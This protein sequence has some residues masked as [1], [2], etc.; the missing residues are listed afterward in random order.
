MTK[1][2]KL[3]I[4]DMVLL[5]LT[6][7]AL[8]SSIQLEVTGSRSGLWVW[9]HV[10][11]CCLFIA[12]IVWHLYLHF[13]WERW[14]VRFRN[15]RSA[16]TRWLAILVVLTVISALL[17]FFHWTGSYIHS[18]IGAIHGKIGFVFLILAIGHTVP[19]AVAVCF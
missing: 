15:Q 4:C 3:R 9:V 13:G 2:N 10:I 14:I 17:A 6:I 1:N 11:V 5:F 12:N 19:Y 8:V 7:I 16:V 18:P